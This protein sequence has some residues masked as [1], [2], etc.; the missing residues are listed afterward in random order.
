MSQF[1][2]IA[3]NLVIEVQFVEDGQRFGKANADQQ[4]SN[5]QVRPDA[6]QAMLFHVDEHIPAP[7]R[8]SLVLM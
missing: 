3:K 6:P 7:G 4:V 5:V 8:R 2:L 1:D